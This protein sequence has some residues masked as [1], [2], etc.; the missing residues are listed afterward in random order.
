[1]LVKDLFA[2]F[3]LWVEQDKKPATLRFY[4][5]RL[6]PFVAEFGERPFASLTLADATGYLLQHGLRPDGKPLSG[7]TK[8]HNAVALERL[9]QYAIDIGLIEKP[10]FK[11]LPKPRIGRRDRLP[12]D[13]ETAALLKNAKPEFRLIY[14]ALR[15][16]GA[17]PGELCRATIADYDATEGAI[18]LADHKTAGKSGRPRVIPVGKKL[19]ELLQQ[20]I[21][22][23]TEGP[24]FRSRTGKPWTVAN[25]SATYRALRN[26]AGLAKDLCLYLTRHEAGSRICREK[27]VEAA[28]RILGHSSTSTTSRYVKLNLKELQKYQ[29]LGDDPEEARAA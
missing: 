15:Q 13:E 6:K 2:Q 19:R 22:G 5:Q 7:S 21:A 20:A 1:M 24:I 10:L 18:V 8:R 11:K 26:K 4:Q 12:T 29:D 27:D 14:P 9:Q 16:S 3:L 17:R 23:R 28:A 25:L